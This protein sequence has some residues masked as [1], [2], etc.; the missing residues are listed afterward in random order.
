MLLSNMYTRYIKDPFNKD[1]TITYL[2]GTLPRS[3]KA[4]SK[5]GPLLPPYGISFK[6]LIL[7]VGPLGKLCILLMLDTSMHIYLYQDWYIT[8][9]LSSMV[10]LSRELGKEILLINEIKN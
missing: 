5:D 1:L 7:F 9:L 4:K 10:M 2:N 3:K 8:C 6:S